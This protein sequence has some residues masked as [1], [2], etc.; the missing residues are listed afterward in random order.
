MFYVDMKKDNGSQKMTPAA[1][2]VQKDMYKLGDI[3]HLWFFM[4]WNNFM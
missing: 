1:R 3:N 4:F 2:K